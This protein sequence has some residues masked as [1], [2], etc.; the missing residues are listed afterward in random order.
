MTPMSILR[1]LS[2]FFLIVIGSAFMTAI[3]FFWLVIKTPQD[4]LGQ[5]RVFKVEPGES[6]QSIALRLERG[7]IIRNAFYFRLYTL[8]SLRHQALK[9]GEYDIGPQFS[10]RDIADTIFQGRA[11]EVRIT[12]PEG[13]NLKEIE[14]LF[15]SNGLLQKGE[16]ENY[17]LRDF[18][19]FTVL[20]DKPFNAG[21]EGYLFPDTY[22]FYKDSSVDD[23]VRKMLST[24]DA[25]AGSLLASRPKDRTIF[26]ILTMASLIEKET[27]ND[28]D[29]QMVSGI[30]WK[31]LEAG[32]P[33]QVDATLIYITGRREIYE[34][35][36]KIQSPYNTYMYRGLPKGPISNPGLAAI[37]S[38]LNP[39]D[40][41]YWYYLNS[42]DGKTIYSITLEQHNRAKA[43]YLR[44]SSKN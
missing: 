37:T 43:I 19:A 26:Q 30:L 25:K 33:L 34:E 24:L 13:L 2:I 23:I 8:L 28:P 41:P 20:K 6:A 35:D 32:M 18:A 40:S 38:V 29:R 31:R 12:L 4:P 10:I 44:A 36:K 27:K 15:I 7:G 39:K 3:L 1:K 5:S 9:R 22:N 11:N 17:S 14:N 21:P 16:L 42:P